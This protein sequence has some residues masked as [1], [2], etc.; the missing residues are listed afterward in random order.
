MS[1]SERRERATWIPLDGLTERQRAVVLEGATDWLVALANDLCRYDPDD[2]GRVTDEVSALG[3]LAS[4]LHRGE[5][6]VPDRMV[7]AVIERR[8]GE[9]QHLDELEEEYE[10][11]LFEHDA[12]V[13]LLAHFGKVDG[14]A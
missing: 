4:W 12:W 10:R 1:A 6:A 8:K 11:E 9:T 13:A 14:D 5:V 7:R 2:I 3:R